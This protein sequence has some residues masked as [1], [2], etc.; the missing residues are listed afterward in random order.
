ML[1]IVHNMRPKQSHTSYWFIGSGS[2][3]LLREIGGVSLYCIV[4]TKVPY[5]YVLSL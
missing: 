2:L 5:K 3:L 4:E 1:Y